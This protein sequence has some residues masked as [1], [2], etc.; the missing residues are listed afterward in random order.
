M[1]EE[2]CDTTALVA[3]TTAGRA[4]DSPQVGVGG[5]GE[6]EKTRQIGKC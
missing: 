2:M 1:H 4:A 3:R 5:E 6:E